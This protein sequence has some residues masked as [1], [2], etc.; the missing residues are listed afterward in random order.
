MFS[1]AKDKLIEFVNKSDSKTLFYASILMLALSV[2]NVIVTCC[3]LATLNSYGFFNS[4]SKDLI[5]L[6]KEIKELRECL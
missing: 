5:L 3:I 2:L 4:D 6:R 1:Q